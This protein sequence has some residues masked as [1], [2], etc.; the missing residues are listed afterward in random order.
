MHNESDIGS[1]LCR[2]RTQKTPVLLT[3]RGLSDPGHRLGE[4]TRDVSISNDAA[5]CASPGMIRRDHSPSAGGVIGHTC[6]A[7]IRHLRLVTLGVNADALAGEKVYLAQLS[8]CS[9]REHIP[10]P[11]LSE[12]HSQRRH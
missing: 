1:F 11:I 5:E 12:P 10:E 7:T 9:R 2:T 3:Y 8:P 6:L 4:A